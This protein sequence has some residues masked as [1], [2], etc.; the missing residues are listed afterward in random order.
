MLIYSTKYGS[1]AEY[2]GALA[3]ELGIRAFRTNEPFEITGNE[4]YYILGSP[5]YAFSVLPAM[6]DFIE[7]QKEMLLARPLAV[8]VVCGDT[9]WNPRKG[10]GGWKNLRKLTRLLPKEP[11]AS[12]V[13]GGRMRMEE[14]DEVDGPRILSFYK[15]LGREATGFDR[16]EI[17]RVPQFA[18]EIR[19][20]LPSASG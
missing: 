8:F 20:K 16:M 9:M 13:F 5:I 7:E 17:E 3:R 1:T 18:A 11:F 2:A 12:A 10:E 6:E 4:P 19:Q 14:L 15:Q